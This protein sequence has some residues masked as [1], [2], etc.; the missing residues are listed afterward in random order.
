MNLYLNFLE[1]K[2]P[3]F[4]NFSCRRR[5]QSYT[6][7]YVLKFST[8]IHSRDKISQKYEA[9]IRKSSY[10]PSNIVLWGFFMDLCTELLYDTCLY[11]KYEAILYSP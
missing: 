5:M 10:V 8:F 6:K 11:H 3:K 2:N 9:L 4:K 7:L 1:K